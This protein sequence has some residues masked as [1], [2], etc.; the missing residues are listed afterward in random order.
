LCF[1][2]CAGLASLAGSGCKPFKPA[3]VQPVVV[4]YQRAKPA[5]QVQSRSLYVGILRGDPET[6]LSFRV[7]GILERIGPEGSKEDW[8]E[9]VAVTCRQP[10]AQ[11]KQEDFVSAVDE[12]EAKLTLTEA[13]FQRTERLRSDQTVSPQELDVARANR[14]SARATLRKAKEALTDSRIY[15]PYDG[16]LLAR[17]ASAGETIMP[18]RTVLRI[19]DLRT[20]V[21]EV[22]VPDTLVSQIKTN[23]DFKVAVSAFEG[24]TFNGQV[25]EVGVAAREGTRL[26]RVVVK[27]P[28][29]DPQHALRAGMSATV[30]F[31]TALPPP[32]GA[33]VVP[34]SALITS[35]DDTNKNQLA[36]FVIDPD[37][38]NVR[39]RRVETG[40]IL[41]SS[42][43]ITTNL[44]AGE[45]VVTFGVA[46]LH[47]GAPVEAIEEDGHGKE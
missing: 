8:R 37:N 30:D 3:A 11:L 46:N 31:G 26:F 1:A 17:L 22:G 34:L 32:A 18:G 15:A 2:T 29:N 40:D 5:E 28:N 47:D 44:N 6:D 33:V 43:I 41:R 27:I 20:N 35:A 19:A 16:F 25:S 38:K 36:V 10:L 21:L 45:K 12:A 23:M 4:R 14:D 7:N 9:G 13:V 39:E 24:I 42:I